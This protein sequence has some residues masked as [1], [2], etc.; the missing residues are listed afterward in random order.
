MINLKDIKL[1]PA[2][3]NKISYVTNLGYPVKEYVVCKGDLSVFDGE[4]FADEIE[5]IKYARQLCVDGYSGS[6]TMRFVYE[7]DEED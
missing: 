3:Y 7:G 1:V 6:I 5:A 4:H 2:W